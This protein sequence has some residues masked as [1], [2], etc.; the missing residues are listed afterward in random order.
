MK[1]LF[2]GIPRRKKRQQERRDSIIKAAVLLLRDKGYEKTTMQDIAEAA[3][4]LTSSVYYYF[5]SKMDIL[6]EALNVFIEES[7][8]KGQPGTDCLTVEEDLIRYLEDRLRDF[9]D[10]NLFGLVAE[11]N[12]NPELLPRIQRLLQ[13]LKKEIGGRIDALDKG[14]KIYS[15]DQKRLTDMLLSLGF[16]AL[17]FSSIKGDE[18]EAPVDL[19]KTL[20]AFGRLISTS[21]NDN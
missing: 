17:A 7:K 19:S 6:D 21:Q 4:F 12:R 16:G 3:D 18:G 20:Q 14:G 15:V 9:G 5:E 2:A 13:A 1:K 8:I 11:A 10:L